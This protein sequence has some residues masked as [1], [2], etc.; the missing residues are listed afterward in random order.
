MY[1]INSLP[2][3][4]PFP[5]T[6]SFSGAIGSSSHGVSRRQEC[7]VDVCFAIDENL[8][9]YWHDYKQET[10]LVVLITNSLS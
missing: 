10:N 5:Q 8:D 1:A 7:D 6:A 2:V 9:A 4:L 3:W